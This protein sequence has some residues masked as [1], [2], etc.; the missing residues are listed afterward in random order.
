[1]AQIIKRKITK[2][3]H[4]LT[5]WAKYYAQEPVSGD[6]PEIK[7][8]PDL[9]IERPS[10]EPDESIPPFTG[11]DVEPRRPDIPLPM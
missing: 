1:M 10:D 6:L 4:N 11:E 3:R 5:R 9:E 7:R 8:P 2:R